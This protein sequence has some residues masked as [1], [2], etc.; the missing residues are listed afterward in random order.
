MG[1]RIKNKIMTHQDYEHEAQRDFVYLQEELDLLKQELREEAIIYSSL[2]KT[3][4]DADKQVADIQIITP[5][6]VQ[7][8][9]D[10]S[11]ETD[12]DW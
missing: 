10:V 8:R 5:K 1:C 7:S 9:S 3:S 12:I 2:E 11:S 6:G 4:E